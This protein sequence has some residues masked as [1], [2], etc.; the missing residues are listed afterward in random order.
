MRCR[1]ILIFFTGLILFSGCLNSSTGILPSSDVGPLD[2]VISKNTIWEGEI[3]LDKHVII[4]KGVTLTILPGT[5][6]KFK[7]YRGYT[8]PGGRLSMHIEG[9]LKAIGTA[10]N[11][12][13][14]TSDANSPRNGDWSM[15][16]LYNASNDTEIRFAI[17]EFAQQ[18][19]NLWNTSPS[20]SD[21]IV[22]WNNW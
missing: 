14:F 20:I 18:G 17:F 3:Y 7:N 12:I 11:P 10:E 1:I 5:V 16:R 6:I 8:S 15:V 2:M 4:P 9:T 19:L 21:I 22:R 13:W